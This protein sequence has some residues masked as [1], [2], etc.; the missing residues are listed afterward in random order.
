MAYK[1]LEDFSHEYLKMPNVRS[2]VKTNELFELNLVSKQ[3]SYQ[4]S[5]GT[6][7]NETTDN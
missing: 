1:R 6:K 5:F 4:D 3:D 7:T 2:Q